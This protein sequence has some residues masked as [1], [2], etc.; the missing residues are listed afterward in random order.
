MADI[1]WKIAESSQSN[2]LLIKLR[3][4]APGTLITAISEIAGVTQVG[5]R[6]TGYELSVYYYGDMFTK[7]EIV[8][9]IRNI[10]ENINEFSGKS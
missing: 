6:E 7:E 5:K 9:K 3:I 1:M 10:L 2:V 4:R 8:E